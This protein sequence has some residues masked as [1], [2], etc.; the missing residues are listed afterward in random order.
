MMRRSDDGWRFAR[1]LTWDDVWA[2]DF[3]GRWNRIRAAAAQTHVYDRPALVRAWAETCGAAA[4]YEPA[5]AIARDLVNATEVLVPWVVRRVR[6]S[7]ASRHQLVFAGDDLFGYHDPL[8]SA[9][10]VD[11]RGFWAAARTELAS[12]C[13]QSLFRFVHAGCA[14]D[15]TERSPEPGGVLRL[16]REGGYDAIVAKCSAN[17]RG[18]IGRRRRRLSERGRVELW[19]PGSGDAGSALDDWHRLGEPSYRQVWSERKRR[20]T[21]WRPGLDA[22]IAR[23]LTDGL[24]DGWGH[25]AT[26][27]VNGESVAWHVGLADARRLY[28]FIP[29]HRRDWEAFAP[30]KVLLSMLVEY[31]AGCGWREL[32]FLTGAHPYKLAWRPD[33]TDLRVVRWHA[34][35]VRGTIL[36]WYDSVQSGR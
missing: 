23:I 10:V 19:V 7:F 29:A 18:D 12:S 11:W 28:W 16:D 15:A 13:D 21:A 3:I 30:G 34:S 24:A 14:G 32:H 5:I 36:S 1:P 9:G 8:A 33:A 6:G 25:Y 20:N 4:E 35:T 2:D 17:H 31:L 26:L 27:R 22:F